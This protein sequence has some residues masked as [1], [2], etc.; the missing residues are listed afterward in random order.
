MN[1]CKNITLII[2]LNELLFF[3]FFT[4]I[5]YFKTLILLIQWINAVNVFSV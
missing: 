2:V 5:M 4:K 1:W 3:L